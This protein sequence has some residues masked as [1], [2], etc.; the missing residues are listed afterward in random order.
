M[1]SQLDLLTLF[2]AAQSKL[3][4]HQQE[5]NQADEYNHDHGDHMVK[6]FDLVTNALK[7]TSSDDISKGL[8]K[9]SSL[10]EGL[11]SGSAQMYAQGLSQASDYFQDRDFEANEILPLLQ[12]LLGGGKVKVGKGAGGLLDS[13]VDSFAGEDG[14]D[15]GDILRAGTSFMEARQ[16]GDSNLEAAVDAII[17][18]SAMGEEPYRARSSQ[19]VADALLDNLSKAMK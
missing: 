18:A 3:S 10:V 2:K 19:L 17:S 6:I 15:M 11:D 12:A 1:S 4:D 16:R 8:S 14:L 9:A 5:L 13:L 7:E